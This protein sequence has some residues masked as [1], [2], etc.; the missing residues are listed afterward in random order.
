MA[1]REESSAVKTTRSKSIFG[2]INQNGES[3]RNINSRIAQRKPIFIHSFLIVTC[4]MN[5]KCGHYQ[6]KF[7]C[8][9]NLVPAKNGGD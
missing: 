7:E 4:C 5:A 8:I 1:E 2:F 9:R 6:P 3:N